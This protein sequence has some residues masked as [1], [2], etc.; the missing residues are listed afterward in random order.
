MFEPVALAPRRPSIWAVVLAGG[1]GRRLEP[2]TRALHGRALPKQFCCLGR[3]TSLLTETVRRLQPTVPLE[4]VV[5]VAED[6]RAELARRQLGAG[7]VEVVGQPLDRGTAPGILLPL[8]RV[9]ARDPD[10]VVVVAPSDHAIAD[11]E[12]FRLG[13]ERAARAATRDPRRIV[14]FGVEADAPRT[15]YG[16]IVPGEPLETLPGHVLRG[17]ECFTEKPPLAR[18]RALQAAGASW[19]TFVMVG[20]GL[21]F[22]N[23]FRRRLPET[24]RF[25]ETYARLDPSR[26]DAWLAAG[27]E[28]LARSDFSADV[29]ESARDL[30]LY[31][32]PSTLGWTDLGTPERLFAWLADEGRLDEILAAVEA[33][34]ALDLVREHLPSPQPL[35]TAAVG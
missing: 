5:V 27:Y 17:V 23:L 31:Q 9:L 8:I 26:R 13:I 14:L 10:A 12:V 16:W 35:A 6:A 34:G 3:D 22:L 15:D 25:F 28:G 24:A 11:G 21:A 20:R 32:W 18:A 29:L 30:A 1:Q 33:R 7:A 19:N 4:R 2:V